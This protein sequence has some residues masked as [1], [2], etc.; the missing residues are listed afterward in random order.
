MGFRVGRTG[1]DHRRPHLPATCVRGTRPDRTVAEMH[2][3]TATATGQRH[4]V[5]GA[6]R[7]PARRC[8]GSGNRASGPRRR[9]Q[10]SRQPPVQ[11]SEPGMRRRAHRPRTAW[12]AASGIEPG[13]AKATADRNLTGRLASWALARRAP[14]AG[15]PRIPR[16][17]ATLPAGLPAAL[18]GSGSS[19]RR[20]P[21]QRPSRI[22]TRGHAGQGVP[23]CPAGG[24][25]GKDAGKGPG[26]GPGGHDIRVGRDP[27][28]TELYGEHELRR[29]RRQLPAWRTGPGDRIP[30]GVRGQCSTRHLCRATQLTQVGLRWRRVFQLNVP[31][32]GATPRAP[33]HACSRQLQTPAGDASPL[34]CAADTMRPADAGKGPG[35]GPGGP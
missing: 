3:Q 5:S 35:K 34:P 17:P 21:G 1:A 25:E 29:Q 30:R 8:I 4:D 23:A 32:C 13:L 27:W 24:A 6:A 15:C 7:D 14:S 10:P 26:K 22:P 28:G 31:A 11:R 19:G 16:W 9:P 12:L 2:A 18:P 20:G 33:G